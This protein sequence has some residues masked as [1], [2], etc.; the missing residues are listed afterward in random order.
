MVVG[1]Y[2][3]AYRLRRMEEVEGLGEGNQCPGE[4]KSEAAACQ[5]PCTQIIGCIGGRIGVGL[6]IYV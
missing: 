2:A 5:R 6:G 4:T 3:G 1:L